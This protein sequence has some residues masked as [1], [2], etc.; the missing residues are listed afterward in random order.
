MKIQ[1]NLQDVAKNFILQNSNYKENFLD[2]LSIQQVMDEHLI[3]PIGTDK[4]EE[5]TLLLTRYNIYVLKEISEE[6]FSGLTQEINTSNWKSTCRCIELNPN[7][8]FRIFEA[9]C[10]PTCEERENESEPIDTYH[11]Q[12]ETDGYAYLPE[13]ECCLKEDNLEEFTETFGFGGSS[14]NIGHHFGHSSDSESE[15]ELEAKDESGSRFKKR[16]KEAPDI[17]PS[18][19]IEN[20]WEISNFYCGSDSESESESE[21]EE[22]KKKESHNDRKEFKRKRNILSPSQLAH[23]RPKKKGSL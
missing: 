3:I 8:I 2:L 9:N 10:Y 18:D 13:Y 23:K 21:T 16:E 19:A 5:K 14:H 4:I 12:S 20:E 22:V 1:N 15:N 17:G 7:G 11:A 6:N